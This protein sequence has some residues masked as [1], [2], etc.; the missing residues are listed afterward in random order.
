MDNITIFEVQ[1]Y[2]FWSII[3]EKQWFY[4]CDGCCVLTTCWQLEDLAAAR[5][6]IKRLQQKV[7]NLEAIVS[8]RSD[9]EKYV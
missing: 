3:Q 9:Y 2:S 1:H 8:I 4:W 6:T 7:E 5:D